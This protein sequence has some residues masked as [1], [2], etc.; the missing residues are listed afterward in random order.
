MINPGDEHSFLRRHA[1]TL[2]LVVVIILSALLY[3]AD[4]PNNPPGFYIDESSISYNALLIARTG[5]DEYGKPWPLY[6]RAFGDYKNP[7]YIYLL[8]AIFRATGPSIVVARLLSATLGLLGAFLFG[9]LGWRMTRRIGVALIVTI[10]ALLTPWLY[11]SSRLVF[12][13]SIYPFL[14]V[15]FLL[16]LW[17]ASSKQTWRLT[18]MLALAATLALLT[19]SYSIGRLLGPLL[20]LGLSFFITRRRWPSVMKTWLLYGLTLIPL[21]IYQVRHSGA[22]NDRFKLLTYITPQSRLAEIARQFTLHYL[23]NINPWRWLVTGE[24]SIRDHL[25]GQGSLLVATVLVGAAG[26]VLVWRNHRR[27]P[28][29]QFILYGLV[30][31]V[32]PAS[33]VRGEFPQLRLIAFPIFFQVLTV[34]AL[35]W[36]SQ[37]AERSRTRS[38]AESINRS[39]SEQLGVPSAGSPA[40]QRRWG[41]KWATRLRR[42]QF[43]SRAALA[44]TVSLIVLQ[45]AYFQWL[46]HKTAAERWYVF[47]ARFE[48][49]VLATALALGKRPIYVVDRPGTPGYI[50]VYWYVVL[51]GLDTSQFVHLPTGK[52]PPPGALVISTEDDCENCRLVAK[53]INYIVYAILPF[54]SSVEVAELPSGA[55]RTHIAAKDLPPTLKVGSKATL[56]VLVKNLGSATWPAVGEPDYHHAV[57]LRNRWLK[58]DG[59]LLTDQDGM[60]RFPYDLE[61]GDTA[62]VSLQIT[63]PENPGEYL[64]ELDVVQEGFASCGDRGSETLRHSLKVER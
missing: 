56:N 3:V 11:E 61:P 10:S 64:L 34:P 14:T 31:S 55:F 1:S 4:S 36:L 47:D 32:I 5:H 53:S 30:V 18:D 17:R 16:A 15:L 37:N 7:I 57:V 9:L 33:L 23:A 35:T 20:A 24:N 21:L 63:A 60:S 6:F 46:F 27:E 26:L 12:E 43:V 42:H 29:W 38:N 48:R 51:R 25:T 50:Q 28:W 40:A 44:T 19:Y 2:A 45:G 49:K 39:V 41:G 52:S 59:T 62:G 54:E 58:S 8:A 22:L 13:V